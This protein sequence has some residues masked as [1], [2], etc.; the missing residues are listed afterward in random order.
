M[1]HGS[2]QR[3]CP[4]GHWEAAWETKETNLCSL[5]F[6][7]P[8]IKLGE[9]SW[10]PQAAGNSCR[11]CQMDA[12]C[13]IFMLFWGGPKSDWGNLLTAIILL[14]SAACGL[15]NSYAIGCRPEPSDAACLEFSCH[16]HSFNSKMWLATTWAWINVRP[17]HPQ[18]FAIF[19]P[20]VISSS[21]PCLHYLVVSIP[22]P[23]F[24]C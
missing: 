2:G 21:Y 18:M 14:E 20:Y 12:G 8:R 6:P 22:S 11:I 3:P 7:V 4:V 15:E 9:P 10:Q 17:R 13:I 23:R 16:R 24:Q 19:K 1:A 5:S